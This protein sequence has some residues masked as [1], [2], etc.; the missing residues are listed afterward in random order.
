MPHVPSIALVHVAKSQLKLSDENYRAI[1][2]RVANGKTSS[3][4]MNGAERIA[5][6]TE[7]RRMGFKARPGRKQT[8]RSNNPQVRK[9]F[10]LWGEMARTGI[11]R[12]GE[13]AALRTYVKR[14]CGV[15]DPEFMDGDQ[16]IN[17]IEG[18][19][20]MKRR[21]GDRAAKGSG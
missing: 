16:A 17:V 11:V 1:C 9:V 7:F 15:D 4:A 8:P 19:K 6:M 5:L 3:K 13:R 20:A 21:G 18:L 14:M 2:A 10:A 12:N